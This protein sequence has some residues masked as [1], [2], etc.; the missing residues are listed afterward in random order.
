MAAM[1]SYMTAPESKILPSGN[2]QNPPNLQFGAY[3][4][5]LETF[6]KAFEIKV[7]EKAGEWES[8]KLNWKEGIR[9]KM[10]KVEELNREKEEVKSGIE[11]EWE[12]EF[13]ILERR[14]F[15][16]EQIAVIE[17]GRKRWMLG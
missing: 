6:L 9:G 4:E 2:D 10:E 5:A 15:L 11:R 14:R 17:D 1:A 7:K 8:G 12:G 3:T 13:W 16:R